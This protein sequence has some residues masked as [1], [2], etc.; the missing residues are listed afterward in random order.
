MAGPNVFGSTGSVRRG[1]AWHASAPAATASST[2]AKVWSAMLFNLSWSWKRTTQ[3]SYQVLAATGDCV[4]QLTRAGGRSNSAPHGVHL[5]AAMSVEVAGQAWASR[6][7]G[8]G[9]APS[10]A[11]DA[12]T[13][14]PLHAT[15][16]LAGVHAPLVAAHLNVGMA[17]APTPIRVCRNTRR[18]LCTARQ[19]TEPDGAVQPTCSGAR[20]SAA[21]AS[22]TRCC[23][24]STSRSK[25]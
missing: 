10:P 5:Q 14:A 15:L 11:M 3:L 18:Q 20:T 16:A 12:S 8:A 17:M 2:V 19:Q 23:T 6:Q 7:A 1:S 4:W 22:R 21:A 24:A 13:P 25:S 9:R